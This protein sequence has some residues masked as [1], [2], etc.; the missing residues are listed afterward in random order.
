VVRGQRLQLDAA[1]LGGGHADLR[2][3]G[4]VP[5]GDGGD[6]ASVAEVQPARLSIE[7]KSIENVLQRS[8][9]KRS[10]HRTHLRGGGTHQREPAAGAPPKSFREES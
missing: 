2:A 4:P 3:A 5:G 7:P 10:I 8:H 9:G 1:E 6:G